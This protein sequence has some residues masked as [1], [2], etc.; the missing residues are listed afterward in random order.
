MTNIKSLLFWMVV[1]VVSL[2]TAVLADASV[3][4]VYAIVSGGSVVNVIVADQPFIDANYP[5]SPRIDNLTPRPTI[6]W[7]YDGANF[8]T[9]QWAV[10][11]GGNV[12]QVASTGQVNA[13]KNYPGAVNITNVAPKPSI[14]W[15]YDGTNFTAPPA[16]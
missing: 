4:T 2:T 13:A 11:Q 12:I 6:G 3:T 7:D 1:S 5:G 16:Q 10:V 8:N 14:G 9:Y 15:G